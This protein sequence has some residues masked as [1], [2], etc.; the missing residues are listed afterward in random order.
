LNRRESTDL[1]SVG[2]IDNT[3]FRQ[4][5]LGRDFRVRGFARDR[6]GSG[7]PDAQIA[8]GRAA[9]NKAGSGGTGHGDER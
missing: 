8:G 6:L 4:V 2:A 9:S 5:T 1:S 7:A 3:N